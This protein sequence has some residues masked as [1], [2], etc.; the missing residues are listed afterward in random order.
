MPKIV[1]FKIQVETSIVQRNL[2][3]MSV[4]FPVSLIFY[5]TLPRIVKVSMVVV[6]YYDQKQVWE[7]N[8]YFWVIVPH[9]GTSSWEAT[10][11]TQVGQEPGG[12]N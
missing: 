5:L 9:H 8:I 11:G 4:V 3:W 2:F 7:E 1:M 12:R 10:L 6:K